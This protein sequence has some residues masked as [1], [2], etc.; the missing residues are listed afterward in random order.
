VFDSGSELGVL[1]CGQVLRDGVRY[2]QVGRPQLLRPAQLLV[3]LRRF[4]YHYHVTFIKESNMKVS[5]LGEAA[6]ERVRGT[7]A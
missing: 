4:V 6:D 7:S 5:Y 2:G 1:A 3:R